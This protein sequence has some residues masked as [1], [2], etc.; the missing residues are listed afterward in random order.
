MRHAFN[1]CGIILKK[2]F[3]QKQKITILDKTYGH[4]D[5]VPSCWQWASYASVGAIIEYEI[6]RGEDIF[7]IRDIDLAFVPGCSDERSLFFMHHVLELCCFGVPVQCGESEVFD[8]LMNIIG[9]LHIICASCERQK[10]LLARFLFAMGQYPDDIDLLSVVPLM[11][12]SCSVLLETCLE[13]QQ[14]KDLEI[15][16]HRCIRMH[17]YGRLLKTVNFLSQVGVK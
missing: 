1:S 2:H 11:H 17:P 14:Q 9:S 16:I 12:K 13:T 7:F 15:F 10:L 6:Q 3:P 4:I 8:I 5:V